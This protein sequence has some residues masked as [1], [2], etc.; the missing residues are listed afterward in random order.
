MLIP[1]SSDFITGFTLKKTRPQCGIRTTR[2][3]E[4]ELCR[5][6]DKVFAACEAGASMF[7]RNVMYQHVQMALQTRRPTPKNCHI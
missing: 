7:L 2:S 3:D 1:V 4:T 5:S 6:G